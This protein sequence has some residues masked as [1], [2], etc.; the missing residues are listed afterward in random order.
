MVELPSIWFKYSFLVRNVGV[1]LWYKAA[2]CRDT[3]ASSVPANSRP[4]VS[5]AILQCSIAYMLIASAQK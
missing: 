4:R 2:L 3:K 5:L 1:S